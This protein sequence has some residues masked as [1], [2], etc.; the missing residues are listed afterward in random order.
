MQYQDFLN[1]IKLLKH[2]NDLGI[3]TKELDRVFSVLEKRYAQYDDPWG[4]DLE[5]CRKLIRL[6]YPFYRHYCK[7][8][9]H[10]IEKVQN[11]PYIVVSNHTGQ[12]PLDAML[13]SLAF[14]LETEHPRILRGMVER[15]LA[16]MPFL[17]NLVARGG[18][19]L[20]DRRNCHFLLS[21]G[22]S[23]L[24]FPEG[25]KGISKNSSEFYQLQDFTQGFYR[26]ALEA[27]TPILPIA[28]VGAEEFYPFVYHLKPL[29]KLLGIPAF[30][31]TPNLLMG[32]LP[33]PSPVDIYI[34]DPIT[35]SRTLSSEAP[36]NEIS[37]HI[38]EVENSIRKMIET[39]LAKR[40]E[41]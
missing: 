17:G 4:F 39:G 31:L 10:N 1:P 36:E 13:I 29:A 37:Q 40:N 12:I 21:R 27:Q 20:G 23:I 30:P 26:I 35:P 28:V 22:E 32:G 6:L 5:T 16:G 34:G 15:F 38:V 14:A 9:V 3:D 33:M 8:K 25:V 2:F 11:T 18:S 7:V 24:V 19:I 41:S